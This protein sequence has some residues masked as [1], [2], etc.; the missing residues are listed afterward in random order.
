LKPDTGYGIKITLDG[1]DHELTCKTKNDRF[2]IGKVTY[3]KDG[4]GLKPLVITESGTAKGYHLITPAKDS[5]ATI[6]VR[7]AHDYTCVIDDD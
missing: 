2:P 3:L 5:R 6:D 7:N 4:A 1:N